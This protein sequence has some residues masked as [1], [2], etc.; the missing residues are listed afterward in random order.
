MLGWERER[1]AETMFFLFSLLSGATRGR[2]KCATV[3]SDSLII[4][5]KAKLIEHWSLTWSEYR[6]NALKCVVSRFSLFFTFKTGFLTG[7]LV[8]YVVFYMKA[9]V[10]FS[11]FLNKNWLWK[12]IKQK[13]NDKR[14]T[15]HKEES[16]HP[17]WHLQFMWIFLSDL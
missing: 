14:K 8:Y 12:T 10:F 1:G 11:L 5:L 6:T 7:S 16:M 4:R 3:S 15:Y 2:Q 17:V 9:D 13:V